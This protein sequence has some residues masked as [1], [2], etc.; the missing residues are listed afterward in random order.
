M[1]YRIYEKQWV[2]A[3]IK[4]MWEFLSDPK[5]L[6]KITPD[7]MK[8]K[9]HYENE[10]LPIHAGQ[11]IEYHLQPVPGFKTH[12]VTEI[13][14]VEHLKFFVDEQRKGPYKMWHHLHRL[15]EKDGGVLMHDLVHYQLPFG[16]VG[17]IAH[18]LFVRKKLQRIFAY[19]RQVLE[20]LFNIKNQ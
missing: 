8:F 10:L 5:N 1:L 11:I 18:A 16:F 14:H 19:R 4:T 3:D 13:T 15:E 17:K 2:N 7:E 6:G 20:Q 9:I 12:W